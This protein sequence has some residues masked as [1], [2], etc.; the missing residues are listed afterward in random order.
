MGIGKNIKMIR[1]HVGMDQKELADRLQ[2]SNKTVSSWECERTNPKMGNIERMSQ[3]F[4]CSKTDLLDGVDLLIEL[5]NET[6]LLLEPEKKI[7][8]NF[9]KR[10]IEAYNSAPKNIKESIVK[11]LNLEET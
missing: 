1:T 10:I 6:P 5:N 8:D 4:N 3:I 7:K 9:E 2:V 11:L